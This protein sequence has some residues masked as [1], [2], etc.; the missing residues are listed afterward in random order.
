MSR[1]TRVMNYI[2]EHEQ[3]IV[4]YLQNLIQIPTQA[5]PGENYDTI[6]TFLSEKLED[7]GCDIETYNASEAY[8]VKSGRDIL[9]LEGPRTNL[10]ATYEGK[11]GCDRQ[12]C[13][14]TCNTGCRCHGS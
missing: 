8:L 5:V 12:Q 9:G 7:L 14:R 3:E 13:W 6:A 11:K 1:N 2:D 4:E 10:V